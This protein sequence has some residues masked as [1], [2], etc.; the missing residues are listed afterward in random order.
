[1]EQLVS[2]NPDEFKCKMTTEGVY[3]FTA[4]AT[5][6]D[7]NTYSDTLA[8]TVHSLAQLDTLLRSKW[9]L[10]TSALQN[11]D[12]ATALT[13]MLPASRDRYQTMFSLLTDQ[14]PA[15][16]ATQTDLVFDSIAGD[17]AFY[18]LKTSEAGSVSS[19]RVIFV[20]DTSTGLWLIQEF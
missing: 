20:R 10:L 1:V 4:Q 17:F 13:V 15:I 7:G 2:D 8:V 14:L 12:I 16:V 3:Y 9:A 19:Y 5:G 18:E 11:K 6:P